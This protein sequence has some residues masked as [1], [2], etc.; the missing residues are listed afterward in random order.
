M[1]IASHKTKKKGKN[2]EG[3]SNVA[4]AAVIKSEGKQ[5]VINGRIEA[6]LL[7]GMFHKNLSNL[8]ISLSEGQS[9]TPSS[10]LALGAVAVFVDLGRIVR[11]VICPISCQQG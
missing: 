9:M 7:H 8:T 2:K 5:L 4:V 6:G 10:T 3:G 11:R 1:R